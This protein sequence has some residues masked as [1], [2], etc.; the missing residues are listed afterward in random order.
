MGRAWGGRKAGSPWPSPRCLPVPLLCPG[1]CILKPPVTSLHPCLPHLDAMPCPF[2]LVPS[3]S[4]P[5]ILLC[6]KFPTAPTPLLAETPPLA[7]RILF[8][9]MPTWNSYRVLTSGPRDVTP[10]QGW[11][12]PWGDH[13]L[14]TLVSFC[15]LLLHSQR[16]EGDR[17]ICQARAQASPPLGT[18]LPWPDTGPPAPSAPHR[19]AHTHTCTA[20][21]A[22]TCSALLPK[23]PAKDPHQWASR[24]SPQGMG[25][26]TLASQEG[27]SVD[28]WDT[29]RGDPKPRRRRK[30]LK[31]FILTPATFW[32]IWHW[33]V[34]AISLSGP[35]S[36]LP[37]PAPPATCS[38]A[39]R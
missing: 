26:L 2:A 36:T 14:L 6:L 4:L 13:Y 27:G 18:A 29:Q 11:A 1:S 32:G 38:P 10:T 5:A 21:H 7:M 22:H 31:T 34:S 33:R 28:F 12:E 37:A 24:F 16:R 19:D 39:P 30:S 20:A 9:P 15:P 23:K 8:F 3:L 17:H 35:V 25:H